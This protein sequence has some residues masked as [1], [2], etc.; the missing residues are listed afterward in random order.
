MEGSS[1]GSR[2]SAKKLK[3]KLCLA[4]WKFSFSVMR[5]IY[6]RMLGKVWERMAE[7]GLPKPARA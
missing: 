5:N 6:Y 4:K 7:L 2:A 3:E 1:A